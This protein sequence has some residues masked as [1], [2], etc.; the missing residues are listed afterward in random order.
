[1][2]HTVE[3]LMAL[4]FDAMDAARFWAVKNDDLTIASLGR[5]REALRAALTEALAQ[6]E[7]SDFQK[8]SV[9]AF[10]ALD[11]AG[12]VLMTVE[13]ECSTESDNLS[14]LTETI[15]ELMYQALTLNGV[16]SRKDMDRK[17]HFG[18][19]DSDELLA[20]QPVQVKQSFSD[21]YDSL[22][23]GEPSYQETFEAGFKAAQPVREPLTDA[24]IRERTK[25]PWVFETV[26]T[27]VR[28][29]ERE[30]GIGVS[31]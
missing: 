2:T 13:P 30:H 3:S 6:R 11:D 14:V 7:T 15:K 18:K 5:K 20:A 10:R 24:W 17:F 23:Y 9:L 22:P 19:L 16:L 28:E 26:K 25:Q 27:W 1:M 4:A 8:W 12:R 31:K 21:W 29:I